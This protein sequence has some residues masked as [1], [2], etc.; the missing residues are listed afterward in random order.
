MRKPV[1][2]RLWSILFVFILLS[3]ALGTTAFAAEAR[4]YDAAGLFSPSQKDALETEIGTLKEELS[5]DLVIVTTSNAQGKSA[6]EYADD[7]YDHGGFGVGGVKSGALLL[8][9]MDHREVYISTCGTAIDYLT[10][11]RIERM[12]DCVQPKVKEGD[13]SG[14]ASAFLEEAERYI[15]SGKPEGQYRYEEPMTL[16]ER[17][18]SI[19][20]ARLLLFTVI[21]LG[22]GLLCACLVAT[23]YQSGYK[24]NSYPFQQKSRLHMIENQNIFLHRHV[25]SRRIPRNNGYG[26]GGSSTHS[27]SSGTTHGGGGRDF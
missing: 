17:F 6:R 14:A 23:K 24:K 1:A 8:I 12:L 4:V 11:A 15:R 27:S 21:S 16:S 2:Y 22:V 26:G 19:T 7:F 20:P 10:D 9:D 5:I 13:Y 25:T 18:H 3:N